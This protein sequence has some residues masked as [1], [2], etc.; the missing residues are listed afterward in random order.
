M[1]ASFTPEGAVMLETLLQWM[2]PLEIAA[3][4]FG[5]ASVWFT[6]RQ[7][8]L[9]WPTGLVMVI[10]YAFIFFDVRLY[11]DMGLQIVYVFVQIYGWHHW[12]KGGPRDKQLPVR[13]LR[14]TQRLTW[15]AVAVIGTFGLGLVMDTYTDAELAYWD[16]ATTV[17]SL[18]A[19]WFM[20]RKILESWVFWI[21]VDV[22]AI[23]IYTVKSLYL[24][25]GLYAVFLVLATIGFF[26]W[27]RSMLEEAR[28]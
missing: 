8:I 16:A 7:N 20:A 19:T 13:M 23:G 2:S 3:T 24:T 6:V 18:I 1:A 14:G 9:C 15:L 27:R 12:L 11:S 4:I 5:L 28:S 17:L 22:L 26:A 21:V 25:A 10:L